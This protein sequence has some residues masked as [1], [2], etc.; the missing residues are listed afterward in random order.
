VLLTIAQDLV[1]ALWALTQYLVMHFGPEHKIWLCAMGQ[2]AVCNALYMEGLVPDQLSERRST[3][4]I[5]KSLPD[6]LDGL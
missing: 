4:Q 6:P 1:I 3:Q 5:F 2:N